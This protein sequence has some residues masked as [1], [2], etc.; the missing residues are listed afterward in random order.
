MLSYSF[1]RLDAN[2]HR[3]KLSRLG[4]D[5]WIKVDDVEVSTLDV[6]LRIRGIATDG[7][8]GE[9]LMLPPIGSGASA[10][11]FPDLFPQP[12][13]LLP[14]FLRYGN[15]SHDKSPHALNY[16]THSRQTNRCQSI[17]DHGCAVGVKLL[18]AGIL[19]AYC[20]EKA[21]TRH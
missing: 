3:A 17:N 20:A 21:T 15:G 6:H 9:F 11:R 10:D 18:R 5:P 13:N 2:H 7:S 19:T 12:L 8:L 1:T 14:F 16:H 4:L